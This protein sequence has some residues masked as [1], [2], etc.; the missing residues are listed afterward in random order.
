M[1]LTGRASMR[2]ALTAATAALLGGG[3][4]TL[5]AAGDGRVESSLLLYSEVNRVQ[6]AEGVLAVTRALEGDRLVNARFTFDALT[7]SSPNGATPSTHIQTFTRPSGGGA[8]LAQ[9]AEIPL[10]DAFKDTRLAADGSLTQPLGRLA[11]GTLG[12][13]LSVEH[14]YTSLGANLGLTRD[15]FRKNTTL[16]A[17]A[18]ITHDIVSPIGGAPV[19]LSEMPAPSPMGEEEDGRR[20]APGESKNT[21]DLVA[22]ATQVLDRS[23]LLRFNYSYSRASG[24]QND[25]YKLVSVVQG[26]T[27]P[28][29]GEPVRYLYES[30][31]DQRRRQAL[32]AQL[33]RY[34]WGQTIDLSYRYYWD[35]WGITS[36]TV[37]FYYRVPLAAGHAITPHVR[38]YKQTG[39]DFYR[40][41]LLDGAALPASVSA[42][43]RL[44]PFTALTLGLQY[45][46]PVAQGTQLTLGA[47]YYHQAGD[48]SPPQSLG[49]LSRTDLFPKMDAVMIRVG[50]GR[51]L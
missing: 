46:L 15:L 14:D 33:R 48:L 43:S 9:P 45:A 18:A 40:A 32:Y 50:F 19:A 26:S 4:H 20:H 36:R 30:R 44:A 10:D 7:G 24:Y 13:H 16:A 34:L 51:D 35:D 2:S 12:A 21:I 29:P 27:D 47:E 42:D 5:H 8:Y 6:T 22:G 38:W 11:S 17:S 23:T 3:A 31:P 49:I 28:D 41:F 1:Q 39:A 25:P 37:D